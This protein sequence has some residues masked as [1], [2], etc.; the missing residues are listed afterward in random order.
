MAGNKIGGLK[1]KAKLLAKDP[2]YYKKLGKAGGQQSSPRKGFGY[3]AAT[4]PRRHKRLSSLGGTTSRRV[5]R[6]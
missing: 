6:G 2:D 1:V 3:T 5:N 4:N